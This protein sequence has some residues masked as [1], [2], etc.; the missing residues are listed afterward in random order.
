[1]KLVCAILMLSIS[2]CS[3][4]PDSASVSL[5]DLEGVGNPQID[6]CQLTFGGEVPAVPCVIQLNLEWEL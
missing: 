5:E 1:M 2:G 4:M 3:L 6:E